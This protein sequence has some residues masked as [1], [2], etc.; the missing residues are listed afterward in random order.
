[1]KVPLDNFITSINER[2]IYYFSS[3]KINTKVPHFFICIKRTKSDLLIMAC[4]TSKIETH[5]RFINK[6]KNIPIETLVR[7]DPEDN[8]IDN[9]FTKVTYVNCNNCYIYSIEEFKIMYKN[10]DILY[11]GELIRNIFDSI[12]IGIHKSPLIVNE[13]KEHLEVPKINKK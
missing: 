9:P 1:M 8:N 6:R 10:D 13:I 4:C 2:K 7:I 12:L 3:E 11:K 5:L